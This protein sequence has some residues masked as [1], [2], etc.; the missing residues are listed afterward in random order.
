MTSVMVH[1]ENR[2]K[3]HRRNGNRQIKVAKWLFTRQKLFKY[4]LNTESGTFALR[5][6]AFKAPFTTASSPVNF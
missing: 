2:W 4:W 1:C 3:G 5:I 6:A